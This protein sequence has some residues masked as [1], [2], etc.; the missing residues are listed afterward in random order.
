MN[1]DERVAHVQRS[2]D[3]LRVTLLAS[4]GET[5]PAGGD[6]GATVNCRLLT[7]NFRGAP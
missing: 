7:V 5:K 4:F 2:E 1:A 3:V 6:A